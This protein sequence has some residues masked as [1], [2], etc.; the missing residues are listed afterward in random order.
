MKRIVLLLVFIVSTLSIKA[1]WRIGIMGG[2]SYNYYTIDTHYMTDWHYKGAWGMIP[3]NDCDVYIGTYGFMGQYDFNDWFGLRADICVTMKNHRQYRTMVSTDYQTINK[4]LQLPVMSSFSFGGKRLRGFLNSGIYGGYW[5]SSYDYGKQQFLMS[6]IDIS[7]NVKNI[8]DDKR[9]QRFDF[10]LVEGMGL[11]WRFNMFEQD[12]AWQIIEARL[13]YSTQSTQ[14][15]Y[16]R[17]KTPR[18]NTTLVLQSGL[19]YFF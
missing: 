8:F 5:L 2:A 12:W 7:G 10:G 4:Y 17:I 3:M 14:K 13:Y 1:Q 15:D 18:Y 19:C 11:E 16:M 9:D 6:N